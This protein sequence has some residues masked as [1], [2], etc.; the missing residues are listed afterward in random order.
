MAIAHAEPTKE[1]FV[2]MI[3]K[4]ISL[5]A[6]ILDLLDNSLDGA[7]AHLIQKGGDPNSV[8]AY[9]G[10]H[11]ELAFSPER[12]TLSDN[13]GGISVAEAENY[14]FHFGR[15]R[16]ADPEEGGIG[17]YGIGMKRAVFK[18]GRQIIVKS[19]VE[20]EGFIVPID[21]AQW[22]GEDGWN[23][24]MDITG[25][26]PEPGT[27]V[28]VTDLFSGIQADFTDPEFDKTLQRV[29]ARDY[30][31]YIQKGFKVVVNGTVIQAHRFV[32]RR[33]EGSIE[34]AREEYV[35]E[36]VHVSLVAGLASLP[37]EDIEPGARP[38]GDP[39]Y[40]GWFVICNDR[41]VL[42]ADKTSATVW[43]NDGFPMWHSQY[44]GFMGLC[45]FT[46]SDPGKLPWT[47]TKRGVD[48]SNAVY[49][50]AVNNMKRLTRTFV[51]YTDRRKEALETVRE[52]EV[53][54]ASVAVNAVPAR[55][56]MRLPEIPQVP[57]VKLVSIQ[58]KRPAEEIT[59]VA[60]ALGDRF[61]AAREVGERT[62]KFY[63]T[64]YVEDAD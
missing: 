46:A 8:G 27:V 53:R 1:F 9:D 37:Q 15:R 3:T 26:W 6:C 39:R 31:L 35:D 36:G 10:Y 62:F 54:A 64:N 2:D 33:E 18:L 48:Q 20:T 63:L 29:I 28:D 52:V 44:N 25:P 14:A 17:L 38:S 21:V 13:C 61:M 43:G 45:S 60:A 19:S 23:F 50:R 34:P 55:A 47:T 12:F 40:F 30:A 11:A 42:A 32:V 16:D 5:E 59:Q 51:T 58:Y 4:D 49:R 7:R 41:V 22:L 56:E 24:K 57:R